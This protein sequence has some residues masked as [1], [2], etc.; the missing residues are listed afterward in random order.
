MRTKFAVSLMAA[1]M[2]LSAVVAPV[3]AQE[4]NQVWAFYL[5]GL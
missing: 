5:L 3:S 1:L 4:P 2:L